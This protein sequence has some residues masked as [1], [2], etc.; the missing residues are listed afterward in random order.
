[1]YI[2]IHHHF[3]YF[4]SSSNFRTLFYFICFA[5]IIFPKYF[6]QI[7]CMN[8]MFYIQSLSNKRYAMSCHIIHQGTFNFCEGSGIDVEFHASELTYRILTKENVAP[9]D[10]QTRNNL[11]MTQGYLRN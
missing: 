3:L 10:R 8:D 1:M 2:I 11:L 5:Y 4:S 9:K 6:P 7:V